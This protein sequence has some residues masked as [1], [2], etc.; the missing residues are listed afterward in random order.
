VLL[1]SIFDVDDT[2]LA[3]YKSISVRW[4]CSKTDKE[5]EWLETDSDQRV[6]IRFDR[7]LITASRYCRRSADEQ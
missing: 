4:S 3:S 1:V 5:K 6:A 7:A 2:G